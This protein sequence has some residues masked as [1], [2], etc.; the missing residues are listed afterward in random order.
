MHLN[1]PA[2]IVVGVAP[3]ASLTRIDDQNTYFMVASRAKQ[4]LA[5][6]EGA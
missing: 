5:V 6:V 4:L 2:V 1:A 3:F